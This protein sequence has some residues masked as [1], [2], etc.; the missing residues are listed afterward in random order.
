MQ[1]DDKIRHCDSCNKNV[2]NLINMSSKEIEET[3]LAQMVTSQVCVRMYKRSDGTVV[4]ADCVSVKEKLKRS[5]RKS[6][7]HAQAYTA[8]VLALIGIS[9]I[10]SDALAQDAFDV[11]PTAANAASPTSSPTTNPTT[12]QTQVMGIGGAGTV[13]VS[14]PPM[15]NLLGPVPAIALLTALAAVGSI[16]IGELLNLKHKFTTKLNGH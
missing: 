6:A 9:A 11:E 15:E 13:R 4:T 5:I 16:C 3:L 1:G 12:D 2:F 8:A 7:L 14:D 10:R